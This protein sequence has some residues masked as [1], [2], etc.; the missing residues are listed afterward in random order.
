M[1][2]I[3]E[4]NRGGMRTQCLSSEEEGDAVEKKKKDWR[5]P[6]MA[7]HRQR[8]KEKVKTNEQKRLNLSCNS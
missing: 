7:F 4:K 2:N 6:N 1:D 3:K 5:K 8:K